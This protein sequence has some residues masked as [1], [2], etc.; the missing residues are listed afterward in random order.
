MLASTEL[1]FASCGAL[2]TLA[3]SAVDSVNRHSRGQ[4]DAEKTTVHDGMLPR[5]EIVPDK[6]M[7]E[8]RRFFQAWQASPHLF[9]TPADEQNHCVWVLQR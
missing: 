5:K 2:L 6:S 1:T 8:P 3:R 9:V 4:Q 7:P